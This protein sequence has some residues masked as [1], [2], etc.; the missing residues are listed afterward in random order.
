[1]NT[2]TLFPA[3]AVLFAAL[4]L[5][6]Q[7]FAQSTN[8]KTP[9]KNQSAKFKS[10]IFK[11]SGNLIESN[12][13]AA[14]ISG[15]QSNTI[16]A[17]STNAA[18]GGGFDN[19]ASN[20]FTTVG[21]G[22]RNTASGPASTVS[23]GE[24]NTASGELATVGGGFRNTASGLTTT[25]GGGETNT[26]SFDGATVGGGVR[27]T[28]NNGWSTVGGGIG[29]TA[30]GVYATVGG[31][32]NNTASAQYGT[33]AGGNFNVADGFWSSVGGGAANAASGNYA[34]VA[35]GQ[36]NAAS[37]Q[38]SF[39]AGRRAKAIHQGSFVWADSTD[40]D[41]NSGG[42][43]QF[44]IRAGFTG[45]NRNTRITANEV[46]GITAPQTGDYGGMYIGTS[47]ATAKPFYGYSV[48]GGS[49]A[50]T[51][52]DGA[53][54]NKWKLNIDFVDRM[55]VTTAGL[56]GI[57][58]TTPVH[59]LEMAS[60]AYVSAGGVW[61]DVSD[62]NSKQNFRPVDSKA[63][64]A[65]VAA[66]PVTKWSYI[67][68]PGVDHIGPVAQDFRAAFG[69]GNND[70]AIGSVDRDGVALAA[71]QGL[72]EELKERDKAISELKSELRAVKE[73]L[74]SLPPAP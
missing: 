7:T 63:I 42:A 1:M 38:H 62:V 23:G 52:V 69:L 21:G 13:I 4:T 26:A 58:T 6:P 37:G 33:V 27:N 68:E 18:I 17:G 73:R 67:A 32:Q 29:N 36:N 66:L 2:R 50:W 39:A 57:G 56:V 12:T 28:A 74:D 20:S 30:S 22:V 16:I 65:K 53:D 61:T 40:A 44:L 49:D 31:G 64:L 10:A 72:V 47:G 14:F 59:P 9:N 46:F 8:V 11:G 19:M 54:A 51:Y 55:T 15:G 5:P 60:G 45:I 43:N 25:I 48:N 41:F 70:K 35:G 71:I 24:T 3:V 34:M